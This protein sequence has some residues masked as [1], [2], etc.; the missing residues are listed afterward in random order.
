MALQWGKYTTQEL[1]TRNLIWDKWSEDVARCVAECV[2]CPK[3]K[4]DKHSRQTILAAM[5]IEECF[6]KEIPMDFVRELQELT[7]YNTILVVTDWFSKVWHYIL[8]KTPCTAEVIADF[9]INNIWKLYRQ[10]G[11]RTLDCG[12][13]FALKFLKVL[14]QNLYINLCLCTAYHPQRDRLSDRAVQTLKQYLYIYCHD[15]ENRWQA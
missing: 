8:A 2:K 5:P 14:K 4:Q 15:R 13:Q 11:H 12:L 6:F 7:G 3:S 9:C 1:A 10:P